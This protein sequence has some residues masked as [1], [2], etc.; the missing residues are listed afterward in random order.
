MVITYL[1][2]TKQFL[3]PYVLE[4]PFDMAGKIYYKMLV[5]ISGCGINNFFL[6]LCSSVFSKYFRMYQ[7]GMLLAAIAENLTTRG[8][9]K[10][11]SILFIYVFIFNIAR[12]LEGA[13]L[14][15]FQLLTNDLSIFSIFP[16][17]PF[18]PYRLF[19]S[20]SPTVILEMRSHV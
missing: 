4:D 12:R 18:S 20:W 9:N 5:I 7:L 13:V 10:Y 1:G 15:L 8:L 11:W 19:A 3:K 6:F 17:A 14:A 2:H 16:F